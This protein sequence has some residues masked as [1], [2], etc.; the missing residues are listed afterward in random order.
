MPTRAW[1]IHIP[2]LIEDAVKP[3]ALAIPDKISILVEAPSAL[4]AARRLER[5]LAE[6]LPQRFTFMSWASELPTNLLT[7]LQW[8]EPGHPDG[9]PWLRHVDGR[10]EGV[11]RERGTVRFATLLNIA[12]NGQD[13]GVVV[14]PDS[15][16]D[17][18]FENFTEYQLEP[19]SHAHVEGLSDDQRRLNALVS[20]SFELLTRDE[21]G[22]S[23]EI[24]ERYVP[25]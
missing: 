22:V 25:V 3:S 8:N 12:M 16:F 17:V 18:P 14:I 9:E 21:D 7:R 24:P 6:R 20:G 19:W 4:E 15:Y 11:N 13:E 10:F 1:R 5:A 2:V 23:F